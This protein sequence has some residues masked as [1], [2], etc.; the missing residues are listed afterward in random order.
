MHEHVCHH[1]N[2]SCTLAPSFLAF[3]QRDWNADVKEL[4]KNNVNTIHF[5]VMSL[6]YVNNTAYTKE[7]FQRLLKTSKEIYVDVHLMVKNPIK[8]IDDF[9]SDQTQTIAFHFDACDNIYEVINTIKYI[10]S[11][12]IKAGIAVNPNFKLKDYIQYINLVDYILIMGVVP[13]KGGQALILNSVTN[14]KEVYEYRQRKG[15]AIKLHFDGGMNKETI[16]LVI[17]ELDL[18]VAGSFIEKHFFELKE[19]VEWYKELLN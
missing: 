8:V 17:K 16:P 13:G 11:K 18:L 3:S 2:H 19:V 6:D 9:V 12:N 7:D 15:L 4:L 1:H 10:Q 5:D 14:L